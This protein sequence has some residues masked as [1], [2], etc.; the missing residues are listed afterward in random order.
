MRWRCDNLVSLTDSRVIIVVSITCSWVK[1]L[2]SSSA[3][4]CLPQAQPTWNCYFHDRFS[5]IKPG[6]SL[7]QFDSTLPTSSVPTSVRHS[8]LSKSFTC[9]QNRSPWNSMTTKPSSRQELRDRAAAHR[10]VNDLAEHER[11]RHSRKRDEV[12]RPSALSLYI[13]KSLRREPR[14]CPK[15]HVH[16]LVRKSDAANALCATSTLNP[17][18]PLDLMFNM[19]M[20]RFIASRSNIFVPRS[21]ALS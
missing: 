2:H 16:S 10:R 7:L 21:A 6:H 14:L 11:C 15:L 18:A 4:T 1:D 17:A 20:Q 9:S 3:W 8:S 13:R 12:G 19:F 5:L